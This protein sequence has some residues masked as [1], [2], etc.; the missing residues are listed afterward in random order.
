METSTSWLQTIYPF[1]TTVSELSYAI[2]YMGA[3]EAFNEK[4]PEERSVVFPVRFKLRAVSDEPESLLSRLRRGRGE[5]VMRN[6]KVQ[7]EPWRGSVL[8]T[9]RAVSMRKI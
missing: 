2:K 9:M 4:F 3:E 8:R 7:P 1:V 6:C 5:S